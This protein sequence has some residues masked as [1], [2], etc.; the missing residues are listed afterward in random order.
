MLDSIKPV[1]EDFKDTTR[2]PLVVP[3]DYKTRYLSYA[4][5]AMASA[6]TTLIVTSLILTGA[7]VNKAASQATMALPSTPLLPRLATHSIPR[8]SAPSPHLPTPIH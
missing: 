2:W 1:N 6:V 3:E 4:Y 8:P 5:F 7:E